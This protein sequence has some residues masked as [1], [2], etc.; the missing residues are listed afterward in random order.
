MSTVNWGVICDDNHAA[1]KAFAS[2]GSLRS[3][4]KEL[5]TPEARSEA[6]RLEKH[7]GAE[8]ARSRAKRALLRRV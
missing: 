8:N 3:M 4:I 1:V 2:G 5:S 7:V 6:Y